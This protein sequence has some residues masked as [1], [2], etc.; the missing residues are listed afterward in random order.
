MRCLWNGGKTDGLYYRTKLDAIR[1]SG[2]LGT[3][4]LNFWVNFALWHIIVFGENASYFLDPNCDHS[5]DVFGVRRTWKSCFEGDDSA[6]AT[7]PGFTDTQKKAIEEAWTQFGFHMKLVFVNPLDLFP[8]LVF[9]GCEFQVDQN[10]TTGVWIPEFG[11]FLNRDPYSCS[12]GAIKCYLEDDVVG[13]F[14]LA[15]SKDLSRAYEFARQLPL[16]AHAYLRRAVK[17]MPDG[18]YVLERDDYYRQDE[19]H[20]TNVEA[21]ERIRYEICKSRNVGGD[22]KL[23]SSLGYHCTLNDVLNYAE[24]YVATT[25]TSFPSAEEWERVIPPG[26]LA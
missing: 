21:V 16:L 23:L 9:T 26:W 13:I 17:I 15:A 18:E 19:G 6:L 25:P 3:S 20:T 7:K 24:A 11:R 14:K 4:C 2:H 5:V 22:A 12:K 1:R 10:G 8:K